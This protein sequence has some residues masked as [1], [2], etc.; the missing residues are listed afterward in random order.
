MIW[1]STVSLAVG[2]LLAQRFK[3]IVLVPA[4]FVVVVVAIA[5]GVAQTSAVWSTILI[6]ASASVGIQIGYFLGM[7]IQYGLGALPA[8][9]SS[10]FSDTR[11]AQN[12]SISRTP[13]S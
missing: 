8:R 13:I 5:V 10:C 7:L 1:L 2:G 4:T 9:K 12:H 3:I 11:T 6:M